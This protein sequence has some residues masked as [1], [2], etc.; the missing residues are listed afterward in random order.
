MGDMDKIS[1]RFYTVENVLDLVRRVFNIT[2][3]SN[4]DKTEWVSNVVF[5]GKEKN[6]W[7]AMAN[8]GKGE[9]CYDGLY[10]LLH[11]IAKFKQEGKT[12]DRVMAIRKGEGHPID[13]AIDLLNEKH[14]GKSE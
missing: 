6:T 1:E 10:C 14:L 9:D 11:Q 8:G 12:P 5:P 7:F 13:I 3:I 2:V 4:K